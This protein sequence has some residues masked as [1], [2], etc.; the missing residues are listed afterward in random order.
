MSL[1]SLRGSIKARLDTSLFEQGFKPVRHRITASDIDLKLDQNGWSSVVE[2][3]PVGEKDL[4]KIATIQ[5]LREFRK[6]SLGLGQCKSLEDF[7]RKGFM[8][9]TAFCVYKEKPGYSLVWQKCEDNTA[10]EGVKGPIGG[11]DFAH[12][13][14]HIPLAYYITFPHKGLKQLAIEFLEKDFFCGNT[15]VQILSWDF[16]F[17]TCYDTELGIL[18]PQPSGDRTL[19]DLNNEQH[20]GCFFAINSYFANKCTYSKFIANNYQFPEN[21]PSNS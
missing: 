14:R 18:F 2:G 7:E 4:S 21:E 1:Y 11:T 12:P 9:C 8:T 13:Y 19:N 3:K 20:G 6:N 5:N 10:I 17:A 16:G 15:D